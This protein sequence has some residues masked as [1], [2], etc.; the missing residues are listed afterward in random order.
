MFCKNCGM[1]LKED[2][3]FCGGCGSAVKK[4]EPEVMMAEEN[5]AEII[6]EIEAEVEMEKFQEPVKE[7]FCPKCGK[8]LPDTALFC[9]GCGYSYNEPQNTE[10]AKTPI[11][12]R[13]VTPKKKGKG[14]I[15]AIIIV[16]LLAVA[17]GSAYY[18]YD[19]GYLDFIFAQDKDDDDKK[20]KKK[21]GD[22]EEDEEFEYCSDC[23][24]EKIELNGEMLCPQCDIIIERE[25]DEDSS[26]EET[27]INQSDYLFPSDREL[28]TESDLAGLTAEEVALI[29]NEIY[30][31]HGYIFQSEVYRT[32]FGEKDWYIPNPN[33]TADSLNAIET[34]N[35]DFLVQYETDMG[36]R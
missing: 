29:R 15:I 1:E 19:N 12:Q 7:K 30:A 18:A 9:G 21:R 34:A 33:F 3:V 11:A 24:E 35:K 20:D 6:K 36:W 26:E 13:P 8:K 31:R 4:E 25:D 10:P 23:G 14:G 17:G 27:N 22:D 5:P 28:I 32:Y 2:A 16:L